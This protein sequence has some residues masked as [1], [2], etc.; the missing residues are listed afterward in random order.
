MARLKQTARMS[1]GGNLPR[2]HMLTPKKPALKKQTATK[3]A[4]TEPKS[5]VTKKS[6][7]AVPKGAL[8]AYMLWFLENRDS[9]RENARIKNIHKAAK[10][11]WKK[12]EDKSE[13]EQKAKE[14]KERYEREMEEFNA[15]NHPEK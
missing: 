3:K 8:S 2:K 4:T 10:Y 7:D 14:D 12:V 15:K 5:K 9:I 6:D 13:W 1:T 11:A